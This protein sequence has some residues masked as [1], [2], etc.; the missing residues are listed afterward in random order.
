MTDFIKEEIKE[1]EGFIYPVIELE[2]IDQNTHPREI[3]ELVIK[4]HTSTFGVEPCDSQILEDLT[5]LGKCKARMK[6]IEK[7]EISLY[8]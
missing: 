3:R 2:E 4:Q 5:F 8:V 7:K 1:E 6:N